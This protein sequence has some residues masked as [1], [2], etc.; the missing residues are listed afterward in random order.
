MTF[1]R[2]QQPW[3]A[4]REFL[5]EANRLF[6]P[7]TAS[8]VS[9]TASADWSP[10]VDIDEYADRFVLRADIAGVDVAAVEVTLEKGVLTLTGSREQAAETAAPERRRS[11]RPNGRFNRR[12]TLPD[13]VDADAVSASGKNGVLEVVIPKRAQVQPRRIAVTH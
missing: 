4:H 6:N 8:D 3:A 5:R 9:T 2:Y 7:A 10:A 13:T 12:F 1:V 11:E